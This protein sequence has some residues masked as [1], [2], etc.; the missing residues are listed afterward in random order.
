MECA[1]FGV[2]VNAILPGVVNT[3]LFQ[4]QFENHALKP[5][6]EAVRQSHPLGR[7]AQPEEVARAVKWLLSN[8]RSFTTGAS[9]SIDGGSPRPDVTSRCVDQRHAT[10]EK[11]RLKPAQLEDIRA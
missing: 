5:L 2:R 3:P 1:P 6:V 7:F 8:E 11:Q 4:R 9:I 10:C